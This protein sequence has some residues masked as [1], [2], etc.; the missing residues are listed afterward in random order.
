MTCTL[1]WLCSEAGIKLLLLLGLFVFVAIGFEPG[2]ETL[3]TLENLFQPQPKINDN[4]RGRNRYP[5]LSPTVNSRSLNYVTLFN[6]ACYNVD[7]MPQEF[8]S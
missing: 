7:E 8:N 4:D 6:V 1:S 2:L 3:E 5:V